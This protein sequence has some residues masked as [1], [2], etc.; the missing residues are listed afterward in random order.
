VLASSIWTCDR[1][2]QIAPL[3]SIRRQGADSISQAFS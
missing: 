1:K 2:N 3:R